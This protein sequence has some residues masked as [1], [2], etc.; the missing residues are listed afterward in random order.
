MKVKNKLK[1][2]LYYQ[3]N[4]DTLTK[5][6]LDNKLL[7]QE[8]T[9]LRIKLSIYNELVDAKNNKK[10]TDDEPIDDEL[11]DDEPIDDE[12]ADDEPTDDEPTDDEPTDDEE[13]VEEVYILHHFI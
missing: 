3:K 2:K 5:S 13:P 1:Y 8:L 7:Q 11:A 12:L 6:K 4:K 9:E 10:S